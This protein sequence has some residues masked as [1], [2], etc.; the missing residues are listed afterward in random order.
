M[1]ENMSAFKVFGHLPGVGPSI[2]QNLWDL[3]L[4]SAEELAASDPETMFEETRL[5]AGGSMD[6]CVLYVYRC[7]V[8][9]ARNPNIDTELQK[10]WNWKDRS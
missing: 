1:N 3:G 2:S 9:Y 10:W 5:L 4:R 8:A 7:A 6:R